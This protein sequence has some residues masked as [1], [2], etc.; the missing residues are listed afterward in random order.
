VGDDPDDLTHAIGEIVISPDAHS[1]EG[2]LPYASSVLLTHSSDLL[3][4]QE[5]FQVTKPLILGDAIHAN[6]LSSLF[7]NGAI[8]QPEGDN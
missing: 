5:I 8:P 4:M 1:N 2:G 3:T 6:D 7:E